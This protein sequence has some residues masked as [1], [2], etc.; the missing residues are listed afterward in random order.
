MKRN[1]FQ[2][3][4][5][6]LPFRKTLRKRIGEIERTVIAGT[7]QISCIDTSGIEEAVCLHVSCKAGN[8]LF[9]RNLKETGKHSKG[10]WLNRFFSQLR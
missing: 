4:P 5:S 2:N 8:S 1:H 6:S 9:D 10:E 7:S 3:Q